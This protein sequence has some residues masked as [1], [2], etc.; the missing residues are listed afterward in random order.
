[1]HF[2]TFPNCPKVRRRLTE[3]GMVVRMTNI[4]RSLAGDRSDSTNPRLGRT[5]LRALGK[6]WAIP[7]ITE[8]YDDRARNSWR[9]IH[10]VI[11]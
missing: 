1:M 10:H 3:I 9:W 11:P 2:E 7:Y 8:S 5:G 4:S 6:K